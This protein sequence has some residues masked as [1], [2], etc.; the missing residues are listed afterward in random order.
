MSGP[1]VKYNGDFTVRVVKGSQEGE[2]WLPA[3]PLPFQGLRKG[4]HCGRKF[5]T[6]K[7]YRAHFAL[8]HIL[9]VA[10]K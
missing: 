9:E 5:W 3:I 6:M 4:C 10:T 2:L 7:G 1:F 8:T